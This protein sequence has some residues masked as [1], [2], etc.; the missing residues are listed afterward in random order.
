MKKENVWKALAWFGI[1][2]AFA[3]TVRAVYIFFVD[4]SGPARFYPGIGLWMG[5][6]VIFLAVGIF[7][8]VH[9]GRPL[10]P[11]V[12]GLIYAIAMV[13]VLISLQV[14]VSC[15]SGDCF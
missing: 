10:R 15:W 11:A 14:G 3:V 6:I 4:S 1:P 13:A 8:F 5:A 9:L 7:T 12:A 2:I